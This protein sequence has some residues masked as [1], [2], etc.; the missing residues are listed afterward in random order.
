M[1]FQHSEFEILEK[2]ENHMSLRSSARKFLLKNK[3]I[4]P[5]RFSWNSTFRRLTNSIRFL[6]HFLI[7]G[8][9][10]AGKYSVLSYLNQ[11]PEIS[12]GFKN[13]AGVHYFDGNFEHN[14][15]AWYRSQFPT[16]I[17]KFK[18][19]GEAPGTYLNHPSAPIRI[20]NV[21]PNVKLINFFRNP[22]YRAYSAYN[23]SVRFGWEHSSFENAIEAEMER[24]NLIRDSPS[25]KLN[26]ENYVNY[27]QF[28]YLR[29]GFYAENL[30]NWYR[31]FHEKQFRH[32]STEELDEN[33]NEIMNSLFSFFGIKNRELTK[34]KRKNVGVEKV[35]HEPMKSKT[36]EFL[37]DF[38]RP[39]NDKLFKMIN[40]K[41]EW[42]E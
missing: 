7:I 31:V 35:L 22:I 8:T 15:L 2:Y 10:K 9:S 37:I 12:A 36:K 11:H 23:H 27:L 34:V 5:Y 28:S 6:P 25:M 18:I 33:Y 30:Q 20:K 40:K 3:Q 16:K 39:H 24:M 4:N 14:S 17:S 19:V 13:H 32:F 41:F 38:Y 29:H 26:N 42:D 1:S 21:L